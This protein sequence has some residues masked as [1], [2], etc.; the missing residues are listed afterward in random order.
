MKTIAEI[1]E[2]DEL[3]LRVLRFNKTRWSVDYRYMN[4]KFSLI[5][6]ALLGSF[7]R[8]MVDFYGFLRGTFVFGRIKKTRLKKVLD[9][10]EQG[11]ITKSRFGV[12]HFWD[13]PVF[14]KP[15]ARKINMAGIINIPSALD[16]MPNFSTIFGV[17]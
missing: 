13:K 17:K 3:R 15:I 4:R 14:K 12:Y 7:E 11:Y 6:I 10:I 8:R 16:K 5:D 1:A 9:M 2:E